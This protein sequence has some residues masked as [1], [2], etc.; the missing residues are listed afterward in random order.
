MDR[1][2]S[3]SI[4]PLV[5]AA[6]LAGNLDDPRRRIIDCRFDLAHPG[7]GE[8]AYHEDHLPGA[9]YA[10]L[11]RDLSG[12][13]TADGGRHPLPDPQQLNETFSAWG[14]D[15]DTQVVCY[16]AQAN[17]YAARLWWL[18][19]WLGHEQVAVLDGG[20]RSWRSRDYPLD[21][22]VP[23][24]SPKTFN[25]TPRT[26]MVATTQDLVARLGSDWLCLIDVRTAERFAGDK[27]P[28]DTV[29]GHIPGARNLPYQ[30]N[31]D[32][33]DCYL[34]PEA[35]RKM[36]ARILDDFP[37]EQC[38]VMCGSGV[39]ACHSLLALE[40]AGMNGAKLYAGSWSEWIRDPNRMV[41]VG[42][43]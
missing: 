33:S 15:R 9:V 38:V 16:D 11:E 6:E 29:A 31:L 22:A 23:R 14:I 7:A 3:K 36:Y 17:A 1:E 39:T 43:N 41:A 18:L 4:L 12:P 30:T 25:G 24:V 28:I 10:H 35:L 34:P 19:R 32:S 37:L 8:A 40:L 21:R 42:G 5:S 27:E 20:L 26:D 2:Y 13:V